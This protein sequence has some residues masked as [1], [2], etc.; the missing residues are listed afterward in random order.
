MHFSRIYFFLN[1]IFDK[2]AILKLARVSGEFAS[3]FGYISKHKVATFWYDWLQTGLDQQLG[4]IV[5]FGLQLF[6]NRFKIALGSLETTQLKLKTTRNN[7]LLWIQN[8]YEF[9]KRNFK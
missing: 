4:Q 8:V 1:Q 9:N 5:T 3:Y 6:T 7:L 2:F